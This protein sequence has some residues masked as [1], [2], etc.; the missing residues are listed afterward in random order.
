MPDIYNWDGERAVAVGHAPE[1][2]HWI[3]TW[4]AWGYADMVRY[5]TKHAEFDAYLTQREIERSR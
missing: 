5:L 1:E 3:G 2:D 4:V